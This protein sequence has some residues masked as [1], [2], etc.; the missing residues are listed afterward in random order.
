LIFD[1]HDDSARSYRRSNI[2]LNECSL[3]C[4]GKVWLINGDIH[5]ADELDGLVVSAL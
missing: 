2:T 1:I 5:L 4:L 3:I